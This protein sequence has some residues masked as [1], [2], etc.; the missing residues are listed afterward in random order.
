MALCLHRGGEIT[1][2]FVCPS[3]QGPEEQNPAWGALAGGLDK[4]GIPIV[5]VD[6]KVLRK[7]CDTE[8]PQGI[9]AIVKQPRWTWNDL[10]ESPLLLILDGIQDPGNCGTILRTALAAGISQVCLTKG[11]VDLYNMKVLRSTMGAIFSLKIITHCQPEDILS[12][13]RKNEISIVTGD[14]EGRNLYEAELPLPLALVV[15]NEGNG[16]SALFRGGDV[17][18]ITIPMSNEVESL[19]VAMATGIILYEIC[20]RHRLVFL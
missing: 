9:L 5:E 7:M 12:F 1:K 3:R 2:V 8:N 20:R 10:K 14:I 19:N 4:K 13:C 18:R 11:T 17:Q 6:E 16:P 15:G